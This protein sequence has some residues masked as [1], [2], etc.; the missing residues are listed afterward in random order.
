MLSRRA[1]RATA[2]AGLLF[3]L[4]VSS[5]AAATQRSPFEEGLAIKLLLVL[6]LLLGVVLAQPPFE[7]RHP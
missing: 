2:G 6:T 7:G 5:V 4:L 1:P 3:F